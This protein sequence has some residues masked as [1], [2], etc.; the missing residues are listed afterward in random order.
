MKLELKNI[1]AYDEMMFWVAEN[2][3]VGD[4][5]TF[6]GS[7]SNQYY[8]RKVLEVDIQPRVICTAYGYYY[9]S[10]PIACDPYTH[11]LWNGNDYIHVLLKSPTVNFMSRNVNKKTGQEEFIVA[12]NCGDNLDTIMIDG[13]WHKVKGLIKKGFKR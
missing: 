12:R 8:Y 3:R 7:R 4:Y 5:V 6:K 1:D 10:Q 11:R 9:G 2:V 13:E